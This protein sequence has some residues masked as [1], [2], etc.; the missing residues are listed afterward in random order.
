MGTHAGQASGDDATSRKDATAPW[1]DPRGVTGALSSAMS[2]GHGSAPG[3]SIAAAGNPPTHAALHSPTTRRAWRP[4][5]ADEPTDART[6]PLDPITEAAK[7]RRQPG[8]RDRSGSARMRRPNRYAAV[9]SSFFLRRRVLCGP[10][11]R[12]HGHAGNAAPYATDGGAS[13]ASEKTRRRSHRAARQ[14]QADSGSPGDEAP[15]GTRGSP[16]TGSERKGKSVRRNCCTSKERRRRN[17]LACAECGFHGLRDYQR[18]RPRPGSVDG[19]RRVGMAH[20]GSGSHDDAI[21]GQVKALP[22]GQAAAE[23]S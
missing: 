8:R 2:D 9:K 15:Q 21:P 12:S 4:G 20:A 11:A 1:R 18:S 3:V 23:R 19:H 6:P 17:D 5:S 22:G 16:A 7:W 13:P 14:F 10:R